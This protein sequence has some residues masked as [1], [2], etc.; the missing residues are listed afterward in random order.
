VRPFCDGNSP[1]L[2]AP[3]VAE[4]KDSTVFGV[5]TGMTKD[6]LTLIIISVIILIFLLMCCCAVCA[7][8]KRRRDRADPE[9]EQPV[10]HNPVWIA[11]VQDRLK[12]TSV[13]TTHCHS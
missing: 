7:M 1:S 2:Q 12:D 13:R 3:Q 6:T 10:T 8:R 9:K 11:P 5:D 4:N